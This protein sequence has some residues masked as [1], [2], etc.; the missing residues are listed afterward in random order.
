[1]ITSCIDSKASASTAWGIAASAAADG[2]NTVFI[3][4]DFNNHIAVDM[5]ETQRSPTQI[6]RYLRDETF[7]VE[8]IQ[9]IPNSP[10]LGFIDATG[11][12]REPSR[13]LNSKRLL[14]LFAAIKKGGYDF[15]VLHAPPVLAA[16]DANWLS[17]FVDGVILSASWGKTTEEQLIDAATQLRMNR[18][19]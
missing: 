12:L 6:G 8:V 7:L 2:R 10:K 19:P 15:I 9:R 13:S 3:D 5:S 16:G 14:E 18:A 17:P 1:M 11:A 4:L